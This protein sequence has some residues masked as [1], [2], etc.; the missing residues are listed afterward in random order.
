MKTVISTTLLMAFS[1]LVFLLTIAAPAAM[2]KDQVPKCFENQ[3]KLCIKV[4]IISDAKEFELR[5]GSRVEVTV[6][7]ENLA[8]ES[9]QLEEPLFNFRRVGSDDNRTR[10][11][12]RFTGRVPT[13][14]NAKDPS[15]II[16]EKNRHI[17]FVVN[18]TELQLMDQMSSIDYWPNLFKTLGKGDYYVEA[19][20][21]VNDK[22]E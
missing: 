12:D 11:G 14:P 10:R 21:A 1:S 19:E 5:K 7:V 3:E 2:Q 22:S 9:Y 8:D 16:L 13:P 18:L 6:R 17:D 15:D 4:R 20:V